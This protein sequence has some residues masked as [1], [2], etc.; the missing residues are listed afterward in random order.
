[1]RF[2]DLD[3]PPN[4]YPDFTIRRQRPTL[5]EMFVFFLVLVLTGVGC[6]LMIDNRLAVISILFTVLGLASY[7]AGRQVHRNREQQRATEFQN[8]LFA[9]ALAKGCRFCLIAGKDGVIVYANP[10]FHALFQARKAG[11][12]LEEWLAAAKVSPGDRK[13]LLDV[14]DREGCVQ[15]PLAIE[16]NDHERHSV[17]LSVEPVE[18]PKGFIL[19]RARDNP[20]G[21]V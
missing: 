2:S 18:R 13:T 15:L 8:S 3:S 16:G 4:G 12:T 6:V 5:V 7:Y 14:I 17:L 10:G 19:L 9:S 1:M 11:C 21:E 20:Q